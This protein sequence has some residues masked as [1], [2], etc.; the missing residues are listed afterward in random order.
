[1]LLSSLKSWRREVK[2][3]EEVD[4][5]VYFFEERTDEGEREGW[6]FL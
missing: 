2:A 3:L 4:I 5:V 1:M 6:S